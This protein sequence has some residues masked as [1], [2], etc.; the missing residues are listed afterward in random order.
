MNEYEQRQEERRQRYL[1]AADKAAGRSE[2]AAQRAT[3]AIA[4]IPPGQPIL[5]GHHSE[6]RHRAALRR[7]DG[8]MRKSID[9]NEKAAYYRGKADGV[10]RAG[11]SSDDPEAIEKLR[12]KLEGMR[13]KRERGKLLNKAYRAFKKDAGALERFELSDKEKTLVTTWTPPYPYVKAPFEPY[14]FSNLGGNI[15][16]VEQRIQGLEAKASQSAEVEELAKGDGW[17]VE[18][19]PEANRIRWYF[20]G[21]PHEPVRK[22]LKT[23]GFRWCRTEGCW[24][25]YDNN[26]GRGRVLMARQALEALNS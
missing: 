6:G 13:V 3:G 7:H 12:G 19:H 22:I 9:E 14:W 24:Q 8:A 17:N 15:K 11:I 26:G 25:C 2:S 1:D 5:V 23:Y 21:K 16:R 20:L 4:G 18:R 10:G